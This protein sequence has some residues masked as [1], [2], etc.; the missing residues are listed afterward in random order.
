MSTSEPARIAIL[1]VSTW[2]A[3]HERGK[4]HALHLQFPP[5]IGVV[6]SDL[7]GQRR[8]YRDVLG[9]HEAGHGEGWVQ[10]DLGRE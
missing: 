9:M 4:D 10:F 8:F 2:Q 6:C 5:W 1:L 3:R 7:E